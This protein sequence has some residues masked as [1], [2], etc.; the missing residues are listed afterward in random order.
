MIFKSSTGLSTCMH[1][2]RCFKDALFVSTNVS[3]KRLLN[4]LRSSVGEIK[5]YSQDVFVYRCNELSVVKE[6]FRREK[7][8]FILSD[9]RSETKRPVLPAQLPLEILTESNTQFILLHGLGPTKT[10]R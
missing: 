10:E 2:E 1:S 4:S 6:V 8:D 9:G 3:P 5:K 7:G